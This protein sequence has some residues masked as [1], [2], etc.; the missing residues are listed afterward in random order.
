VPWRPAQ[1]DLG[2]AVPVAM[3]ERTPASA[4]SA[5]N[6]A[7]STD[8]TL[9]YVAG[10][11]TRNAAR[12]VW[13]DRAGKIEAP[14]LPERNYASTRISADGK[15]AIVEIEEGT[16]ALWMYDFARNI[17]TP[18]GASAGSSQAPV[19]TA[20]GARVI[21][22]ATRKGLRNI[23]WRAADGSGDEEPLTTKADV[24]QEPS[25]VSADGH[26]LVFD[27]SGAQEAGGSGIRVMRLDG[28]RTPRP[29][30]PRPA[31]ELNGQVSP[32]GKWI[33]YE[34]IVSSRREIYVA[35]FP[36]PGPRHQV[37]TGG[38]AEPLWSH[39][40]R[41]LFFQH[42][43]RLMGVGVTLGTAFSASAPHVVHEGRFLQSHTGPTSFSITPDGSRFLR[44]Q[45]VEPE[46]AITRIDLV[47]NWFEELKAKVTSR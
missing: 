21:Y 36:G 43:D 9:V 17:L 27:E 40:G 25:S 33:A 6:Y 39:D 23:Y 38:G 42:G 2:Q 34:A 8:G 47:L 45:Q 22:R 26:W 14:P 32:D 44:I 19:W 29:L 24:L 7:V 13:I 46:R 20:D 12:L 37:S 5:G 3:P 10:G 35:P 31:A 15:R 30:F 18:I 16:V 4:N 41:E 1:K 11:R 28:D